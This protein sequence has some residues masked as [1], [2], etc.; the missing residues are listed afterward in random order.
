MLPEQFEKKFPVIM[1]ALKNAKAK[2]RIAHAYL[3]C[4]DSQETRKKFPVYLAQLAACG[5]PAKDFSPCGKCETCR[6]IESGT[7]PDFF[8]IMPVS[9]SRIIQVGEDDSE[10]NTLRW[11][12]KFF[13]YTSFGKSGWKLGVIHDA[14]RMNETAQN[15]FLKTLEEPPERSLIVLSTANPSSLLPTIIS[16]CQTL[17]MLDNVCKYDFNGAEELFNTLHELMF[18]AEGNLLLSEKC[19]EGI[20]RILDSLEDEADKAVSPQWTKLLEDLENSGVKKSIDDAESRKAAA[21]NAEYLRLRNNVLSAIHSYFSQ[22]YHLAS[23]LPAETLADKDIVKRALA[24]KPKYN[25]QKAYDTLNEAE[26]LVN[27]LRWN[28]PQELALR[29]FCL[30]TAFPQTTKKVS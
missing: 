8:S 5:S 30:K 12:E 19:T 17:L 7:Y 27:N 10:P 16:R 2:G 24:E 1:T 23:G 18:K 22:I 3:L 15:A 29:V 9:K 21:I 28:V 13:H 14:D 26:K 11:F 6:Q 25:E 4:S 20:I